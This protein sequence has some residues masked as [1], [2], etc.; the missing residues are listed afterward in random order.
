MLQEVI[1]TNT[2]GFMRH[3]P[4]YF[5]AK[6]ITTRLERKRL[7][8]I[9][10][11]FVAKCA[12]VG[13]NSDI[14]DII[15][16]RDL[17]MKKLTQIYTPFSLLVPLLPLMD[18]FPVWMRQSRKRWSGYAGWNWGKANAWEPQSA[19]SRVVISFQSHERVDTKWQEC[20]IIHKQVSESFLVREL[21]FQQIAYSNL[22]C[23]YTG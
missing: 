18:D 19:Q 6:I 13:K 8:F 7:K 1:W 23:V 3:Q 20:F 12:I 4:L 11:I 17:S 2:L 15:F 9:A 16:D 10:F 14:I 21:E 5:N 22:W